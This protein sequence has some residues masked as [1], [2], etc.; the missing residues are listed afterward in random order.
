MF[1]NTQTPSKIKVVSYE[2]KNANTLT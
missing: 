1:P 2:T